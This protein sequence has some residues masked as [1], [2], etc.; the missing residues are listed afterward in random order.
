MTLGSGSDT[1]VGE[2]H[3]QISMSLLTIPTKLQGNWG[4][5]SQVGQATR[6]LLSHFGGGTNKNLET[7]ILMKVKQPEHHPFGHMW[8]MRHKKN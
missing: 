4:D 3:D 5:Q 6:Q 1:K 7:H 8:G 2:F